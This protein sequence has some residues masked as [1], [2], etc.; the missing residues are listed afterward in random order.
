[1]KNEHPAAVNV[2]KQKVRVGPD[3]PQLLESPEDCLLGDPETGYMITATVHQHGLSVDLTV[4]PGK[5]E[6]QKLEQ[7]M[8]L[9]GE[10]YQCEACSMHILGIGKRQWLRKAVTPH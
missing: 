6:R 7:L 5:F 1:M 9:L 2:T 4:P 8:Q 10:L 3:R